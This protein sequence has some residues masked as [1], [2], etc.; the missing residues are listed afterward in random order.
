YA[1]QSRAQNA[2][3]AA[4]LGA[5]ATLSTNAGSL[6]EEMTRLFEANYPTGY[7]GSSRGA[8]TVTEISEGVYQ[9][10]F[11]VVVPPLVMGYFSASATRAGILSEVTGG[12]THSNRRLELSLVLDNTGS[13][14][15]GAGGALAVT[16]ME[17]LKMASHDLVN[18]LYGN[19]ET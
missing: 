4:L 9:A 17:A 18:I 12:H 6:E 16:K 13:M 14:S 15:L 1:V 19:F 11:N 5:V 2:S 10:T 3:D 8:I 7:M